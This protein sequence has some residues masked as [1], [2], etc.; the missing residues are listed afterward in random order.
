MVIHSNIPF[1]I[2][3]YNKWNVTWLLGDA[4]FRS[5][6]EQYFTHLLRTLMKYFSTLAEKLRVFV[7][8]CTVYPLYLLNYDSRAGKQYF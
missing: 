4:K 8:P 7:Q 5:R 6:V 1:A 2:F 3:L